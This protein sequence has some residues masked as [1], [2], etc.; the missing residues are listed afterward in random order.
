MRRGPDAPSWQAVLLGA[1]LTIAAAP[2]PDQKPAQPATAGQPETAAPQNDLRQFRVGMAV[3]DLPRSGYGGFACAEAPTRTLSGW[4]AYASC[5]ADLHGLHAVAFRY[6][7]SS[8][9]LAS[10]ND[11]DQGTR[12]AGHPA[13]LALLIGDNGMVDGIRIATDPHTRLYL[14]K[15]AFLFAGQ[16]EAHFGAQGWQCNATEPHGDETPVGGIFIDRTCEKTT[17]TRH[18]TL[19]QELYRKAGT[20][21]AD[22]VSGAQL[23]ILLPDR[24]ASASN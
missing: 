9:P 17:P 21:P 13:L 4:S 24:P 5:P 20:P 8:N 3:A 11:D 19:H 16:V 7:E 10:I 12:V 2:P 14:H 15:K 22:F 18:F 6:E 23:T 1:V